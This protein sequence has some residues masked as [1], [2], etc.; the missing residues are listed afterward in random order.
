MSE[1][2]IFEIPASAKE[3][4]WIDNDN[5][6]KMYQESVEDPVGFWDK[7]ADRLDWF[8]KWDR[9]LDWDYNKA[10]IRW[11]EGGKLNV[12]HNC[13]D[14]H[15]E[16]RG[17]QKALIWES[18][19][20][21]V[22]RSFTYKQLHSEVSKFANVMKALGVVKGDRVMIYMPMIPELAIAC[23]ACARIGAVHSVVFG[24]FSSEAL[25]NRIIDCDGKMLITA[26]A[27]VRGGK[28]V[29]LKQNADIAMEGTS[30]ECCMVVKHTED[31]C[32]MQSG[33]DYF[34]HEEMAKASSDCPAEEM[35]AEDPLFILYTSGSTGKPKGVLHTTAGYLV[36]TSLTHQYVFD[37]HDGD[38]YWC[39][40]DIGWVTGHSYILYGPLANGATTLMFE[41]VPNYPD[42]GRFW[43]ICDKH[44]VNIFY[45]A[46]TAIRAIAKEGDELVNKR[47]LSSLRLLG[48]VGEPINPEAWLWYHRVV[49]HGNCPIVDTWWQTETG[50]ILITPLPGATRTK[51]GSATRPFFGI[52]PLL[53]DGDGNELEGAASG[54]LCIKHPWPGQMRTVYGDH[55]RFIQTYF[56]TYKGLYFTGDGCRRDEDGYYWITGRV[57][58]VLNVSGHRMGTAELESALV[59]HENVAEAAVVGFPHEIKG[60]GIYAFVTLNTGVEPTDEL[61]KELVQLVRKE[62][63][64]IA[65]FDVVQ[66]APGLPK[67]RSGKIMRRILRKIAESDMESI[68]DTSTLADPSV[69]D[70]L[71]SNRPAN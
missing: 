37:Y 58:D 55:E 33:R 50:G 7:Q 17:D 23:L 9:T 13:L 60:Q 4:A 11:Y 3:K 47:D 30:I 41:G 63:G 52:Q 67:T 66:W 35:D 57:D 48:T 16:A 43:D 46:P 61:Q 69:V 5:Y 45:T 44:K 27:G 22:D 20:P 8:K 40:A 34:W 38:I 26:N 6:L 49:G 51:P 62:I 54:N 36:Y 53:V 1:Q 28:S 64:P 24:G 15:L 10:Y 31:A 12:S 68:G 71:I 42:F 56:S 65:S 25:K 29:P 18:D 70:D 39:T 32:E 21:K 19:D 59:L 2:K 14:R